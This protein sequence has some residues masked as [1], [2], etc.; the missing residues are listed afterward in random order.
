MRLTKPDFF[1]SF[2]CKAENCADN[3]CIGWEIDIDADSYEKYRT[4][5]GDLGRRLRQSIQAEDPPYFI[6][7][8]G[9][10][11][12]FLNDRNL[13]ALILEKGAD[14]LCAICREHPRFYA[15]YGNNCDA[16]LGLCCE[17]ACRLLF[18]SS[19]PM[20]LVAVETAQRGDTILA[21]EARLIL[22]ICRVRQKMFSILQDRRLP[23]SVRAAA[24]K[25][26]TILVQDRLNS[27]DFS[28]EAIDNFKSTA[29]ARVKHICITHIDTLL[30]A[31][32]QTE[33]FDA[34]FNEL[35]RAIKANRKA[36]VAAAPQFARAMSGREWEYEK[37]LTY[38]VFRWV[39]QAVY[40]GDILSRVQFCLHVLCFTYVTDLLCFIKHGV[41]SLQDRLENIRYIS[42]QFEYS[43]VN[44]NS[45]TGE[46]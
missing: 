34:R 10:R 19:A 39:T 36:L 26:F 5:P 33:P 15:W 3:C 25:E 12:P 32:E 40:D 31:A 44:V 23:F 14:F 28:E 29:S 6:L 2:L 24:M 20:R 18:A 42:K 46:F 1:D 9:E 37:L 27:Q 13:C 11:C 7:A 21:E 4:Q 8:A 35:L 41:F 22:Y 45:F 16:G 17:E 43:D 30:A 38:L